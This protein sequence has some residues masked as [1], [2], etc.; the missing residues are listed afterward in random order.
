M[1]ERH[2]AYT[3]DLPPSRP[4]QDRDIRPNASTFD[5]LVDSNIQL[6]KNVG[7]LVRVTYGVLAFNL[8]LVAIVVFIL[9]RHS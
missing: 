8:L 3:S 2:P 9:W 6:T 1:S 7:Q 4:P 5:R